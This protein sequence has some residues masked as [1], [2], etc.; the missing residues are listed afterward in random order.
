MRKEL[1]SLA[2]KVAKS[3]VRDT[4][5]AVP[6]PWYKISTTHPTGEHGE[7]ERRLRVERATLTRLNID[8]RELDEVIEAKEQAVS[9]A[10]VAIKKLNHEVQA[11]AS[12]KAG[13]VTAATNLEKQY[14]WIAEESQWVKEPV[15]MDILTD[16]ANARVS[17]QSVCASVIAVCP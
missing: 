8:L 13:D 12:E 14:E 2:D 5:C 17:Q 10:E 15:A 11:L 9:D 7:A 4:S 16:L 3:E 1:K 6:F